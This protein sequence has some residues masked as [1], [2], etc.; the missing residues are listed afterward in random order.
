MQSLYSIVNNG[1]NR[2]QLQDMYVTSDIIAQCIKRSKRSKSDGNYGFKPDHLIKG[3][4]RLHILLSMLFESMLI[5]CYN[6]IDSVLSSIISTPK[7]IRSSL[8]IC[9]NYRGFSL[10]NGICTLFNYVIIHTCNDYLYT[11]DMQFGFKPQRST[12]MCSLVYHEII[13]HYMSNN[14]NVYSCLL[15]ASKAFDKVHY[16]KLFNILLNRKVPFCIIR[17]LMDSFERQMA[18]VMWNFHVSDYFSI[19][20]GV[21]QGVVISPVMFNLYLV[22]LLIF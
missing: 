10:F 12:T 6:A 13:N 20:N 3:G 21:K 5:H 2:D 1:I 7:D 8:G 9:D 18:R 22:N 4:K 14:S 16:G 17:L 15:D 11:S 19:S